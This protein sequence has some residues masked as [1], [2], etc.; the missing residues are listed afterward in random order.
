M[1][2][3]GCL[4]TKLE[5]FPPTWISSLFTI[6]I[7]MGVWVYGCM[8]VWAYGVARFASVTIDPPTWAFGPHG[9][10][11][12]HDCCFFCLCVI[13]PLTWAFSPHGCG[14]FRSAIVFLLSAAFIVCWMLY[15]LLAAFLYVVLSCLLNA[16]L[17][18]GRF[19]VCC[20]EFNCQPLLCVLY[21]FPPNIIV[22]W[23]LLCVLCVFSSDLRVEFNCLPL[24]CVLYVFPPIIKGFIVCQLFLIRR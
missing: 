22:C 15:C 6:V 3:G 14:F 8:C 16:L 17:F 7:G 2:E 10:G 19:Y 23:P 24:L 20:V 11:F 9:C 21:V 13:F 5:C 12:F 4:D 1:E 18:V